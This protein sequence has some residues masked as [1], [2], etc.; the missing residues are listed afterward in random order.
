MV[1]EEKKKDK[2]PMTTK[3]KVFLA[4]KIVGNIAFYSVLLMLLIF[5]IMNI[6]GGN[7]TTDYPHIFGRGFLSVQSDSMTRE[8]TNK[9]NWPEEWDNYKIGSFD[10]GDLLNV[11]KVSAKKVKVGDVVTFYDAE[12]KALNSHRVVAI[13]K[14]ADGNIV[15]IVCQGD[16][17]VSESINNRYKTYEKYCAEQGVEVIYT[18]DG[19]SY[20]TSTDTYKAWGQMMDQLDK[21]GKVQHVTSDNVKG[22]TTSIKYGGGETLDWLHDHWLAVF[23]MPVIAILI[24]EIF[25]VIRN[26]MILRGE[27]TVAALDTRKEEII[28]EEKERMRLELLAEMYGGI[29]NI[30]EEMKHPKKAEEKKEEVPSEENKDENIAEEA[31]GAKEEN[32]EDTVAS[33]DEA[34]VDSSEEVKPEVESDVDEPQDDKKEEN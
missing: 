11:K 6:N 23:I 28:A 14:D 25:F 17:V 7:G 22:V 19:S 33:K 24:V 13:D 5:S 3:Q 15:D 20:D 9:S 34:S 12:I 8:K 27:K 16:R 32:A 1:N 2:E 31:N 30:P 4:L 21:E 26:I 18:E 29:E 10:E